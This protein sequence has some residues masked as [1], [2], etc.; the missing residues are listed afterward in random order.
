MEV[1][2]IVPPIGFQPRTLD[3]EPAAE[4]L[5]FEAVEFRW[6]QFRM[7]DAGD[8]YLVNEVEGR[9]KGESVIVHR[10]AKPLKAR[11]P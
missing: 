5:C 3:R 11:K 4:A 2:R 6:R 10:H 9:Y 8:W 7:F 1:V